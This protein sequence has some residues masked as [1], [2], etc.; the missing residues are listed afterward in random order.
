MLFHAVFSNSNLKLFKLK[1]RFYNKHGKSYVARNNVKPPNIKRV[2]FDLL[3]TLSECGFVSVD[4]PLLLAWY[5]VIYKIVKSKKSQLIAEELI[6]LC[7]LKM[8]AVVLGQEARKKLE[9]MSLSDN[10]M[11]SRIID[12][13]ENILD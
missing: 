4:K 11:P 7:A 9:L 6:N 12:M 1:E 2:R 3:E 8:E 13:S 5:K 10:I